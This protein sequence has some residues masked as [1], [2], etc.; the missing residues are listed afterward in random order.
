MQNDGFIRYFLTRIMGF[1]AE[2][3]AFCLYDGKQLQTV[4]YQTFLADILQAAGAFR[5]RGFA[6]QR[7]AMIASN[8]YRWLVIFC[9][10]LASGNTA[11]PL[12]PDLPEPLLLTLCRRAD[13]KIGWT[14]GDCVPELPELTWLPGDFAQDAQPLPMDAVHASLKREIIFLLGTSGTTGTSKIA[15][16][17]DGNLSASLDSQAVSMETP[18]MERSLLSMPLYHIGGLSCAMLMLLHGRTVCIGR[19]IKYLFLDMPVLQPTHVTLVPAMLDSFVKIMK[20]NPAP[21]TWQKQFGGKLKRVFVGGAASKQENCLYLLQRGFAVDTGYAMTETTGAGI[22]CPLDPQHLDTVGKPQGAMEARIFD[23]EIQFKGP[24]VM[25]GYYRD[26]AGTAEIL[27]D[28]WLCTGDLGYMDP[29]GRY[30][31]TGRKKNVIILSGGENVNPEE[32]EGELNRCTAILECMVYADGKGIRADI[33]TRSQE[34]AAAYIRQY[35]EG[36]PMYRRLHKVRYTA[37]PLQKTDSGKIIRK[38]RL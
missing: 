32:I 10:I 34:T 9:G 4:T 21:E 19:G 29:E 24:C 18:G 28:G 30:Y 20:R 17:S 5:S 23:G 25:E 36:V 22:W 31:I 1:S 6:G 38:E 12:N 33:Y 3:Q 11:V 15:A 16:I 27:Q 35:N 2:T 14:A 13:L 26:P 7:I 37:E 8:S